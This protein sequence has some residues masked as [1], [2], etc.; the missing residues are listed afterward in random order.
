MGGG[1]GSRLGGPT[2]GAKIGRPTSVIGLP[3]MGGTG[4]TSSPSSGLHRITP[5]TQSKLGPTGPSPLAVES[6]RNLSPT[7]RNSPKF[8]MEL[9]DLSNLPPA[10]AAPP[11]AIKNIQRRVS[12]NYSPS[13]VATHPSFMGSDYSSTHESKK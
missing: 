1:G 6:I 13:T 3:T 10:P 11:A 8:E 12:M 7:Y 4:A 2:A 9:F 5:P